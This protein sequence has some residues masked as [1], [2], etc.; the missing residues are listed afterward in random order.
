[1]KNNLVKDWMTLNPVTASSNTTL[2][3]AYW[4]M[5]KNNI[6]R[7]IV[8]DRD[9]LVG[10]ITLDDIRHA[11]PPT[12]LG[13][14]FVRASDQLC[15]MTISQIM[16]KNPKTIAANATII[17]AAEIMMKKNISTLPVIDDDKLVGII[18]ESDIFRAFV[19][20]AKSQGA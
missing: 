3:E 17:D 15:K 9:V 19:R 2:P 6:R 5:M 7:L 10:I 18:T 13:F 14:D 20:N 11:K 1:M 12:A 16:T 4:I 8:M